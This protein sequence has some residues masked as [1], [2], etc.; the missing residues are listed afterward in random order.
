[1]PKSSKSLSGLVLAA[2]LAAPVLAPA[3]AAAAS[4]LPQPVQDALQAALMDEYHA[5]AFYAAVIDRF[6]NYR[7]F[8]NIIRA[9]QT[10]AGE[11]IAL[12]NQYGIEAPAN[13]LLDSAEIRAAVPA[14]FGEACAIGVSAEIDNAGLYD[15]R[16]LPA[17]AGYDD[18]TAV[19][20]A[21]RDA[22]QTKHLPAF[23]RCVV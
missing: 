19:L 14:T 4:P 10:H 7:P 22:S 21:L 1:M 23:Q 2:L 16:L 8:A 9:E 17:V 12:M 5:E 13:T 20:T 15:D 3:T 6:G 11:I 18:I